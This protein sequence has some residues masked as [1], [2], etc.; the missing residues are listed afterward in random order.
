MA[1]AGATVVQIPVVAVTAAGTMGEGDMAA[2][3]MTGEGDM[4]A[5]IMTGEAA[6]IMTGE[7]AVDAVAAEEEVVGVAGVAGVVEV[8]VGA[9]VKNPF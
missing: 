7:A 8:G 3:I 4:A 6:V 5:V 1:I 9:G 2:V